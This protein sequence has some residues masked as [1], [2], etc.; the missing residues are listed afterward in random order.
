VTGARLD[1][2]IGAIRSR[3]LANPR[4]FRA[5]RALADL[6][7]R[8]V[9]EAWSPEKDPTRRAALA[10]G[11]YGR[12]MLHPGS[13]LDIL[14]FSTDARPDP[15][16]IETMLARLGEIPF[17]A[18]GDGAVEPDFAR[19]DPGRAFTF[20]AF[21]DARYIWGDP[22]AARSFTERILPDFI[23]RHRS[24]L[25]DALV[26]TRD[27]KIRERSG[28]LEAEPDLKNSPGGLA[29]CRW[30]GWMV[31]VGGEGGGGLDPASAGGVRRAREFVAAL[32]NGLQFVSRTRGTVLTRELQPD[33]AR[34]LGF[35]GETTRMIVEY[36]A[37]AT[38]IFDAAEALAR[39]AVSGRE[40][41]R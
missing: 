9:V 25:I 7:D 23:E 4:G 33:V 3:F 11:G 28:R 10:V 32:R 2:E 26:S 18:E 20:G 41:P 22:E 19:F 15:A 35:R 12:R 21:L 29:D 1:E 36:R 40:G 16:W 24:S 34:V 14:F 39:G 31:R 17:P 27:E 5:E 13:D 30:I 37:A 38:V 6:A 8:A